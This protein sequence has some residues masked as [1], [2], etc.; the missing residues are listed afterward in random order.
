MNFDG[1]RQ[2]RYGIHQSLSATAMSAVDSDGATS[3]PA[4]LARLF[5]QLVVRNMR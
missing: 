1:E 3:V 2:A 4:S 5:D